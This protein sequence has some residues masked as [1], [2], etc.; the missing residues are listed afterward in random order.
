MILLEIATM[1][2]EFHTIKNYLF[3]EEKCR[4]ILSQSAL[5]SRVEGN[6]PS[7]TPT[8]IITIEVLG[9]SQGCWGNR[10][11]WR[12]IDQH[13]RHFF[14]K[15]PKYKTFA[16]LCSHCNALKASIVASFSI[17]ATPVCLIDG[18]PLPLCK[19]VRANRC[20]RFP[21]DADFSVCAAKKE[22]YYGLKGHCLLN[23]DKNIVGFSVC[24]PNIDERKVALDFIDTM[25]DFLIGDKGYISQEFETVLNENGVELVTRMR[26]NMAQ[27]YDENLLK[28]A[29]S[30]RKFIETAFSILIENFGMN[31]NTAHSE[32]NWIAQLNRK[33]IAYNLTRSYIT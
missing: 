30:I 3:I 26:K 10:A 9:E 27:K 31:K 8:E 1:N 14:P 25:K 32:Q 28:K 13:W 23:S 4:D 33:I 6:K 19:Y 7:L 12:Y 17:D 24:N 21:M 20:K 2:L 22:P 15:L 29:M 5:P 11:I 16:R 18:V